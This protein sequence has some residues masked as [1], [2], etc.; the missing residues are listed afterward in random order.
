MTRDLRDAVFR[1]MQRLP[2]R[3]FQR[4]KVGQIISKILSDTDQTKALDH[5]AGDAHGAERSRRSSRRSPCCSRCRRSSR[6][7]R[8]SSRRCS[9]SRCSRC[10]GG[11]AAAIGARRNDFGESDER[12]AGSRER[13]S[14]REVVRR[15]ALRGSALRRRRAIATPRAWSASTACRRCRSRSPR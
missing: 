3:Y 5:R 6:C 11:C 10:C 2:L 14:P 1:H 15:R 7:C 12:A 9:R 4:T 8:S 13:R